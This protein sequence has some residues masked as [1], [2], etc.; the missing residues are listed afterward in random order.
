[1]NE[2]RYKEKYIFGRLYEILMSSAVVTE[3]IE[4]LMLCSDFKYC[5]KLL[6]EYVLKISVKI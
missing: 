6:V 3:T 1:V 5:R 4:E 2:H